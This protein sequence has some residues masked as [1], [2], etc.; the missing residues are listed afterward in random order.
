MVI[1]KANVNLF[2]FYV[3]DSERVIV[4]LHIMLC[5]VNKGNCKEVGECGEI[6]MNTDERIT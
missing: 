3:V 4:R 6:A 1:V 2:V 5:Y